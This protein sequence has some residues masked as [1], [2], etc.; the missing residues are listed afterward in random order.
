[1]WNSVGN[2]Y[3]LERITETKNS[4]IKVVL[5]N[6]GRVVSC[7]EQHHVGKNVIFDDNHRNYE[8]ED[9]L[10]VKAEHVMGVDA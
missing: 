6:I 1:M 7:P 10:F 3:V 5:P 8:Y 2:W 9:L 4:G